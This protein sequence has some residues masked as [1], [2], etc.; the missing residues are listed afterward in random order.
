MRS[1]GLVF[2]SFEASVRI[3]VGTVAFWF[4]QEGGPDAVFPLLPNPIID[5][6]RF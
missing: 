6:E 1:L 2:C 3:V 4:G 5:A